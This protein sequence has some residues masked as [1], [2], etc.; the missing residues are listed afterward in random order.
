MLVS[1]LLLEGFEISTLIFF[2]WAQLIITKKKVTAYY[3]I[4]VLNPE[5]KVLP[6]RLGAGK[7]FHPKNNEELP[8]YKGQEGSSESSTGVA[9]SKLQNFFTR[10]ARWRSCNLIMLPSLTPSTNMSNLPH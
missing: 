10:L 4:N 3:K 1:I 2:L 9:I 8:N 6:R 7:Y 5:G